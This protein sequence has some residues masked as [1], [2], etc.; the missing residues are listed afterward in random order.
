[1]IGCQL[2]QKLVELGAEVTITVRDKNRLTSLS[3]QISCSTRIFELD[4]RDLDRL[5]IVI[6]EV[7]PQKIFHLAG[8]PLL[9][10][11]SASFRQI[12]DVNF[13]GVINILNS[14]E[15]DSYDC[16]FQLGTSG[17]FGNSQVPMKENNPLIPNNNY[18][19]SKACA[20]LYCQMV[21]KRFSHPIIL[22]RLFSVYA[23]QNNT[24]RFV[25]DLLKSARDQKPMR[26][27]HGRQTRDFIFIEDA[28]EAIIRLAQE[29][30]AVG[31]SFNICSGQETSLREFA[32][33]FNR[34]LKNPIQLDVDSFAPKP[35][36]IFRNWGDN[37]ELKSITNWKPRYSLEQ[38]IQKIINLN[39]L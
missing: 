37:T 14:L 17:E 34:L 28:I 24:L 18:S 27:G 19:F 2:T 8:I 13:T 33:L 25:R 21:S 6:Q 9:D 11:D 7:K 12:L 30:R 3:S 36:E 31:K 22:T 39:D 4:V 5:K 16:F 32:D 35:F 10:S 23:A 20:S 38:G 15:K 26:M 29:K 1:M